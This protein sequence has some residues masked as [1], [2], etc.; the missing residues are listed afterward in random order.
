M[1]ALS[2]L[3]PAGVGVRP[4]TTHADDRGEFT[5]LFRDEWETGV[6][7]VQWNAVRSEAGV[8]RGVHCHPLHA[9]A[10]IVVAGMM[11]LGLAD[12][13]PA[14]PTAGAACTLEL[15]GDEMRLVTIPPGVAHGFY[16]PVPSLHVYAVDRTW[17]PDDELG[18]RWDDPELGLDWE[19]AGPVRISERDERLGSFAA[20]RAALA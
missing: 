20:L 7:P 14:S 5:E 12:L 15:P 18:C 1:C 11:R 16:F 4:L 8:V 3:L 13:R 6:A 2:V 9:D 19:L 17:D 10:L